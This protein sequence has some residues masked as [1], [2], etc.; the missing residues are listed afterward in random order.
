MNK[1]S[2]FHLAAPASVHFTDRAKFFDHVAAVQSRYD[3]VDA[4]LAEA[5]DVDGNLDG[6][7]A[8]LTAR[9]L[10]DICVLSQTPEAYVRRIAKSNES[11]AM[12]MLRH[13]FGSGLLGGCVLLVDTASRRVDG[14]V[15]EAKHNPPDVAA[16][17]HLAMSTSRDARF[18]GGWIAGTLM[19]MTATSA[20]VR[21][22]KSGEPARVGD[23]MS[24]GFEIL[25]DFG[26]DAQTS[27]ADYAERLSCLNGM[28]ARDSAHV[29]VRKHVGFEID[30]ALLTTV[31]MS[32]E[33]SRAMVGL[34]KRASEHFFD[35]PGVK[36]VLHQISSSSHPAASAKLC[37]HAKKQAVVE[38]QRDCRKAGAL[39][40]WDFVNG[41]TDAAKHEKTVERRRDVENLGYV[42]MTSMLDDA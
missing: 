17:M 14:V 6:V 26:S 2:V 15:Q 38:A 8:R 13:S 5:V 32:V 10:T 42:L 12:D 37:E 22:V 7:N 24:T 31:L 39:C 36:R 41:V 34:A 11:L 1:S 40:L 18:M 21:D 19:R 25:T 28:L 16:L 35:G 23:L 27:I 9:A 20:A 4:T 3:L 30:D 33:R 29:S